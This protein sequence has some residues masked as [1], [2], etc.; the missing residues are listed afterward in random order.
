MIP[1]SLNDHSKPDSYIPISLL[2]NI[3]NIFEKIINQKLNP[4]VKIRNEQF[5][6]RSGHSTSLKLLN[7]VDD[8]SQIV[9]KRKHSDS[10]NHPRHRKGI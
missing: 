6:F 5:S 2:S 8:K 10:G 3:L 1:K 4:H 9:S 7:L